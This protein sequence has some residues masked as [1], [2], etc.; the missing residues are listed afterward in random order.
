MRNNHL[1]TANNSS[2]ELVQVQKL[3]A[4]NVLA[5]TSLKIA[6][7]TGKRHDNVL[8]E[9]EKL[10]NTGKFTQLNF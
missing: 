4:E 3:H 1:I 7:F 10:V 6:E 2:Q 8:R 9:I 5:T